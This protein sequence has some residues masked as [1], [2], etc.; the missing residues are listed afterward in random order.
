VVDVRLLR[1]ERIVCAGG[2]HRRSVLIAAL[3]LLRITGPRV[4]EIC[5]RPEDRDA[6]GHLPSS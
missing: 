6:P 2:E 5:E 1:H 3:D 4:A